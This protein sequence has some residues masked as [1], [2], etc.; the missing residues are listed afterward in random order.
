[1]FEEAALTEPSKRIDREA[2]IAAAAAIADAEGLEA[3][4]LASVAH[5]LRKKV[6]S[7]YN[8]V[9]GFEGLIHGVALLAVREIADVLWKA[10][11]GRSGADGIIAMANA[12]RDFMIRHPQR[13]RAAQQTRI[14]D[15]ELMAEYNRCNQ[16][17]YAVIA[18]FNLSKEQIAHATRIFTASIV[19]FCA[20]YDGPTRLELHPPVGNTFDIMVDMIAR[21]IA[22]MEN[23][24]HDAPQPASTARKAATKARG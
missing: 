9:D 8:H 15:N 4:T 21:L 17:I 6:S 16:A 3:V 7:L 23:N 24:G 20:V 11:L 13:F 1:M 18:S 5:A 12:F 2:V 14:Y 22:D 10:G 19:G